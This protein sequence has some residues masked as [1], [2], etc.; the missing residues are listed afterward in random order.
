MMMSRSSSRR[1]RSPVPIR[2]LRV[3]RL[4]RLIR[5]LA[6]A[7]R[8]RMAVLSELQIGVRTFYRELELHRRCGI[9]VRQRSRMYSPPVTAEEAAGRLS[10]PDPGLSFA[11]MADLARC[12]DRD[13]RWPPAEIPQASGSRSRTRSHASH[14][15]GLAI[16]DRS[17]GPPSSRSTSLLA[18]AE[19][20]RRPVVGAPRLSVPSPFFPLES[21]PVRPSQCIRSQGLKPL[22]G[23]VARSN[24]APKSPE[25][26]FRDGRSQHR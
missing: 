21:H 1:R 19:G 8:D 24:S 23:G 14:Q 17:I 6:E 2:L 13:C 15:F 22:T 5:F 11:E 12:G 16:R 3:A 26:T 10:F 7:S 9:K 25:R 4:Y 18:S 20:T